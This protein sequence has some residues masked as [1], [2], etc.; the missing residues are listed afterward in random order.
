VRIL[1]MRSCDDR[2]TAEGEAEGGVAFD[3][4]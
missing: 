4:E 1:R 2:T 3:V